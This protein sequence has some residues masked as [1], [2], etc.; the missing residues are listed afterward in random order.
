[1]Y[2]CDWIQNSKRKFCSITEDWGIFQNC[3]VG[4]LLDSIPAVESYRSNTAHNDIKSCGMVGGSVKILV[5][6]TD[7]TIPLDCVALQIK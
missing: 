4:F 7:I 1:M 6:C 3:P 2:L 5:A